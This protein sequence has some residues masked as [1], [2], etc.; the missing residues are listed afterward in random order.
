[1]GEQRTLPAGPGDRMWAA[2][3]TVLRTHLVVM[4]CQAQLAFVRAQVVLHEVRVLGTEAQP[5]RLWETAPCG[6]TAVCPG[7]RARR[8]LRLSRQGSPRAA[9]QDHLGL[10]GDGVHL[11]GLG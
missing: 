5:V 4:Q 6:P 3:G 10:C 2:Q 1:M 9:L 8:S 7:W 11:A